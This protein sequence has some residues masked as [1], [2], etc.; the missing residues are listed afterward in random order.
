MEKIEKTY[1]MSSDHNSSI[2][3]AITLKFVIN[4]QNIILKNCLENIFLNFDFT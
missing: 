2:F 4:I 1:K 3:K